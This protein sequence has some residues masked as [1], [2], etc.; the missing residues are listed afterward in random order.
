MDTLLTGART[1]LTA[2]GMSDRTVL[3]RRDCPAGQ[4]GR[5]TLLTATPL[6]L[7]YYA[8]ENIPRTGKI[9]RTGTGLR[10][11]GWGT[12]IYIVPHLPEYHMH[13][14]IPDYASFVPGCAP[15]GPRSLAALTVDPVASSM[16]DVLTTIFSSLRTAFL[17]VIPVNLSKA[18]KKSMKKGV[19]VVDP[20]SPHPYIVSKPGSAQNGGEPAAKRNT[21]GCEPVN[22]VPIEI[23]WKS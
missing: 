18:S 14:M 4:S 1:V 8:G 5:R 19:S 15:S 3:T 21:K 13:R 9:K 20:S 22:H 17:G 6:L 7:M 16:V 10:T 2:A 11:T 23:Y 12:L